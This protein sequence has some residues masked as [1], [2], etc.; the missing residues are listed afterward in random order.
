MRIGGTIYLDH[1]ATTPIDPQVLE[2]MTPFLGDRFGNP[3]S[4]EHALGWEAARAVEESTAQ[5]ARLIGADPD[6]IIFTSGAT[7]ANNLALLGLAGSGPAR[8]RRRVLLGSSDHKSTLAVGRV[9]QERGFEVTHL[10]VDAGGYVDLDELRE[11]VSP[12]VLIVSICA[13]NSEIGT[14]QNLAEIGAIVRQHGVL[15]HCDAAQAPCGMDVSTITE[16]AELVSVSA[17]KMYGP[18][19]IGALYIR[20]HV[21][22]IIQP[23]IHG[24]GQQSNLRSGTVP[25]PLC[26]GFGAAAKLMCGL[27]AAAERERIGKLRDKFMQRLLELPWPV[28]LNGTS[29]SP[30]HPGNVNVRF[31]GFSG[32]D[33]LSVLQPSLAASTGSACA[34]GISEASYVLRAIGLTHDEAVSSVRFCVGRYTTDADISEAAELIAAALTRLSKA[35]LGR[36][37]G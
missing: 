6:E 28:I 7:E 14:I 4:S 30:R 16:F 35:G 12:S 25:T 3:H 23:I 21:Q 27:D 11:A 26:V 34:S 22:R 31:D 17:H 19:G 15:L 29:R 5:L 18:K 9:L 2:R 1:Q 37:A 32:Q 33:L 20:R 36:R 24:G 8:V 13:V 10:H